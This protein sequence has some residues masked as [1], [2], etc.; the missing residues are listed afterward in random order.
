MARTWRDIALQTTTELGEMRLERDRLVMAWAAALYQH[1][2]IPSLRAI[3]EHFG[4]DDIFAKYPSLR[5]DPA[6][7]LQALRLHP[8]HGQLGLT[9]H[10]PPRRGHI[11]DLTDTE[12]LV[13]LESCHALLARITASGKGIYYQPLDEDRPIIDGI[14]RLVNAYGDYEHQVAFKLLRQQAHFSPSAWSTV[15]GMVETYT[16]SLP[17]VAE[18][19]IERLKRLFE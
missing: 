12:A 17:G 5:I 8:A 11:M 13:L 16:L 2:A 9:D 18:H 7:P 4:L 15:H 14:M 6:L 3:S 19:R 1:P 10:L